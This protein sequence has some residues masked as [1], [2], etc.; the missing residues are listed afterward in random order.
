LDEYG[1]ILE[2]DMDWLWLAVAY[3]QYPGLSIWLYWSLAVNGYS[4]LPIKT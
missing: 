2:V 4:H 1:R 3:P